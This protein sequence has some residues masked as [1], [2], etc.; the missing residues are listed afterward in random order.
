[1]FQSRYEIAVNDSLPFAFIFSTR[2]QKQK[3]PP[4]LRHLA[5]ASGTRRWDLKQISD[6]R[7][8]RPFMRL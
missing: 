1:M 8:A 3:I 7:N 2:D 5:V 4:S 6:T